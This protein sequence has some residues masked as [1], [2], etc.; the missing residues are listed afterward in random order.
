MNE[1][2]WFLVC[3]MKWF[4]E[5]GILPEKWIDQ[6]C[7]GDWETCVRYHME[8]RGEPHPDWMLPDGTIDE[9]RHQFYLRTIG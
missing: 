9:D 4:Y 3:P 5:A 6:Y 1:C 8:E 2:K 7:K